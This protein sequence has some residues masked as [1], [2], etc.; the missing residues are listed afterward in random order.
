MDFGALGT[1]ALV[2]IPDGI[3]GE[4]LV[5]GVGVVLGIVDD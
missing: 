2:A 3:M 4:E 1:P 5:E